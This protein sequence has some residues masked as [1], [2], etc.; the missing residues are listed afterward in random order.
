[1]YTLCLYFNILKNSFHLLYFEKLQ[2]FSIDLQL[3]KKVGDIFKEKH[4]ILLP[5]ATKLGQGNIF[6]GICDS[7]HRGGLPQCMLGCHPRTRHSP[8]PG[9]PQDQAPPRPGTWDQAPPGT[10][11]PPPG[12]EHTGRY[13]Q[14]AGGMHPTGMQ[15]CFIMNLILNLRKFCD[16][17]HQKVLRRSALFIERSLC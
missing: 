17:R 7:V 5:P 2:I 6:T 15:S 9:T 12:A 4:R 13:G 10:R 16:F 14:R 8:R 3:Q 1:M 11:H